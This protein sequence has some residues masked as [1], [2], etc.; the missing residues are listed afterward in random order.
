L[1]RHA[2]A[3][4]IEAPLAR[5]FHKSADAED[6]LGYDVSQLADEARGSADPSL[7]EQAQ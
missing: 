6:R 1:T 5:G 3:K 4:R 7:K 2:V